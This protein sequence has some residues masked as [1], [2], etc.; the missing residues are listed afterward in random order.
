MKDLD[1]TDSEPEEEA[2]TT[3]AA[4]KK[5]EPEIVR[6]LRRAWDQLQDD[7][8]WAPLSGS[9]SFLKRAKPDF[10]PRSYGA[11]KLSDLFADLDSYFEVKK[12]A[13]GGGIKAYRPKE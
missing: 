5:P 1:Q 2:K 10:D 9:G 11:K 6:L 8:G 12:G 13:N 3:A 7:Q 4:K